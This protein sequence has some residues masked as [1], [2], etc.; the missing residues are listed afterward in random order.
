MDDEETAQHGQA[1]VMF[2][3]V[4]WSSTYSGFMVTLVRLT[5]QGEGSRF[6][7]NVWRCESSWAIILYDTAIFLNSAPS[8][9]KRR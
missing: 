4:S 5:E 2:V 6:V 3:V 1:A 9:Q 8:H 7:T